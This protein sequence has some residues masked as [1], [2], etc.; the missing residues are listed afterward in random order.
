M[1]FFG[2][3]FFQQL[4]TAQQGAETRAEG[5][6]WPK[7]HHHPGIDLQPLLRCLQQVPHPQAVAVARRLRASGTQ[8]DAGGPQKAGNT[9]E[10]QAKEHEVSDRNSP[11][12]TPWNDGA[13][14]LLRR[15]LKL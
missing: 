6:P 15:F 8:A 3:T 9:A 11:R 13:H 1:L 4:S 12:V 5:V 14:P 10:D 2:L 7:L